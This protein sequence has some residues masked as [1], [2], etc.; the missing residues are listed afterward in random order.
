VL[1][2]LNRAHTHR[3]I[4]L[5]MVP[6]LVDGA[7]VKSVALLTGTY[8]GSEHAAASGPLSFSQSYF[9]FTNNK[10]RAMFKV[11]SAALAAMV[12]VSCGG[13]GGGESSVASSAALEAEVLQ[14]R[15]AAPRAAL[16]AE[17]VS[18]VNTTTAGNQVLRSIGATSDGGYTV[19]WISGTSTF[20]IQAYDSAG[21]KGGAETL[22]PLN[23]QAETPEAAAQAI[24][25]ASLAVLTDGSVVVAYSVSRNSDLP[26]GTVS[27]ETGVYI[28]RFDA[29]GAQ[30][31]GETEV[32]SREE[33]LHSRSPVTNQLTVTALSDGGFIV[34]WAVATFSAQ[35]GTISTLSLRRYDSQGQPVGSPVEVGDF[36]AL[37]YR[38]VAD[39][40]GGFTLT[41]TQLDNFFSTEYSVFHYDPNMNFLQ[42]VAPRFGPALLLP[43]EGEYVLFTGGIAPA[44]RQMLD[45]QGNPVGEAVVVSS[46]PLAAR[47]LA[48]GTYIVIWGTD[49]YTVQR[50][51]ASGATMGDPVPIQSDGVLPELAALADVGLAVAWSDA[52]A[53]V[54]VDVHT[55]RFMESQGDRK[56]SCLNN[57]KGLKGHERK[58][59]MDACLA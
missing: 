42:V 2:D 13:G 7:A 41:T 48:D 37:T 53:N 33:V 32:A 50:F 14:A 1:N 23:V 24:G 38:I 30:I 59:F 51:T 54:D 40:R 6:R 47:E 44:T 35:F 43:L 15:R 39:A 12:L 11:I 18:V 16:I 20:Y 36:P 25:A 34:G 49:G 52:V 46:M 21:A 22:I 56:K 29:S 26:N 8:L 10:V 58:A 4:D 17:P 3:D 19:A 55:Q 28:Q 9:F 27:T 5:P 31:M 57:A 45:L